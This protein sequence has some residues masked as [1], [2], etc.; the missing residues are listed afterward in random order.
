MKTR[1]SAQRSQSCPFLSL[2][3]QDST[4]QRPRHGPSTQ[5]RLLDLKSNGILQVQSGNALPD[6][7]PSIPYFKQSM[8]STKLVHKRKVRLDS[9]LTGKLRTTLSFN[10]L[11]QYRDLFAPT[12]NFLPTNSSKDQAKRNYRLPDPEF[13]PK[14]I[15][16][17]ARQRKYRDLYGLRSKPQ[18]ASVTS[19]SPVREFT[20]R[21]RKL[22]SLE[23]SVFET[24]ISKLEVGS[25][26]HTPLSSEGIIPRT[27][28]HKD[29][30]QTS[31]NM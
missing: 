8:D 9:L 24:S 6:I 22:S 29:T 3:F 30:S 11:Q 19:A 27:Q 26:R 28:L 4:P 31:F 25:R 18:F 16:I 5:R 13:K 23:S 20:S 21:E 1:P 14:Y 15:E 10:D 7:S 17:S 12:H 2:A